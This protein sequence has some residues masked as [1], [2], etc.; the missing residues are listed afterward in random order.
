MSINGFVL[1]FMILSFIG[2][3]YET[4]AM[5][6]WSGKFDN[7]GFLFG[8]I[9]PIYGAGATFGTLL[10]D[11]W[12]TN[13]TNTQ[14]FFTGL[15]VSAL[16]EYPTHYILEKVFN[17]TWWDYTKAPLN[18]NGRVCLPAAIGFGIGAL[19]IIKVLNPFLIPIINQMPETL[20][21]ILSLIFVGLFSADIAITTSI[22][23]DFEDRVERI[24]EKVDESLDY[25]LSRVL[26]E[27]KPFKDK[28]YKVLYAPRNVKNKIVESE[29]VSKLAT[30]LK[31]F[32][33]ESYKNAIRRYRKYREYRKN[34][35]AP[36]Q[37]D[38]ND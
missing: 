3:I 14:I 18:I 11:Y 13:A 5:T 8:P 38:K 27:E 4:I 17:Q 7:R 26:N 30:K 24:G 36:K 23:S 10:F 25:L 19:L 1:Y 29:K 9:I 15:I 33:K 35:Y 22:I 12:W 2:Y 6:I 34:S 20:V 32:R 28:A 16:I 31:T 21:N 37:N